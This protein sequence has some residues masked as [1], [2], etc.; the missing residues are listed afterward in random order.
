M[1]RWRSLIYDEEAEQRPRFFQEWGNEREIKK[2]LKACLIEQPLSEI[3]F[4]KI[5][6]FVN[7]KIKNKSVLFFYILPA[8][9]RLR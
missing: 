9:F 3:I 5:V 6:K 8:P 7:E 2:R 1:K 4:T